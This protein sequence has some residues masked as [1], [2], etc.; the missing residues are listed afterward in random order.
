MSLKN[1]FLHYL[2]ALCLLSSGKSDLCNWSGSGLMRN[3][4]LRAV[5]Q[6]RLH[7]PEGSVEW[8]YPSHALRVVLEPILARAQH[9]AVCIKPFRGFRGASLFIER[10]GELD[11]LMA[12]GEQP[13]Q[14]HCFRTDGRQKSALFIQA[15]PQEDISRR[16]VGFHF[17][18]LR[19]RSSAARLREPLHAACQPCND[20]ELLLAICNS[21]FVIRGSIRNVS[22]D[23][24]RRT[25]VVEVWG[26]RVYRQ[27]SGVFER[28]AG[29]LA[30][31]WH[32]HIHTR[33]ECRVRPGDGLFLFT[34][35]E[36][37]GEA[38]LGCAPRFRDFLALYLRAK[39]DSQ[40]PCDF[41]LD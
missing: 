33:L 30:P 6:V 27:R 12:D 26:G 16:I 14:V 20:T 15:N 41:P 37:F 17:E 29:V 24:E 10:T 13:E 18:F 40:N 32:G 8:I 31:S 36:H 7:C 4:N 3:D 39:R 19:K 5:Q 11:L 38:W 23:A 21:D 28:E 2:Q 25:S 34:G 1:K 35:A 9:T 22:H